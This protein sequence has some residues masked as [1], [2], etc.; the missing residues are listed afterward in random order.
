MPG[1]VRPGL[2]GGPSRRSLPSRQ[3]SCNALQPLVSRFLK[4]E[5]T[6]GVQPS[7]EEKLSFPHG[8]L[9]I[10]VPDPPTLRERVV[11]TKE[12]HGGAVPSRT[13]TLGPHAGTAIVGRM[14]IERTR[15]TCAL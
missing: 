11:E 5:S 3:S 10:A 13:L 12:G 15:T 7:S 8:D 2:V 14:E 6:R 1:L 9:R 4:K